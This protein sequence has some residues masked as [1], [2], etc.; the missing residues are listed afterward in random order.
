LHRWNQ[1]RLDRREMLDALL[2]E[3]SGVPRSGVKIGSVA[4][5]IFDDVSSEAD[6]VAPPGTSAPSQRDRRRD[7]HTDTSP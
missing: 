2:A 3:R 5:E 4:S 7:D 1:N 6:I